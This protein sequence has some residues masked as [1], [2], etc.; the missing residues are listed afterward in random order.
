MTARALPRAL[1]SPLPPLSRLLVEVALK[2]ADWDAHRRS[3]HALA[4]LAAHLV[5]D[6]GLSPDHVQAECAKPFWRD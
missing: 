3:R 4:R 6:L 1:S 2:L 5:R